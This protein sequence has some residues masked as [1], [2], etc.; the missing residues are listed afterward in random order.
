[1]FGT[2]ADWGLSVR[3]YLDE[4]HKNILG[5]NVRRLRKAKKLTQ[6]DLAAKIQTIGL[7]MDRLAI[8]RIEAGT[9]VIADYEVLFLK[10]AL[11]LKSIDALFEG[12]I[13]IIE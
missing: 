2:I 10:E 8:V 4:E 1:M 5:K 11:E 7:D 6:K 13:Q 9:R 12:S 3:I